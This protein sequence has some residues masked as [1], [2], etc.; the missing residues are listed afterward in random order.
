MGRGRQAAAG[1]G[2]RPGHGGP[3][4]DPARWCRA[5]RCRVRGLGGG[6]RAGR[7]RRAAGGAGPRAPAD[8]ETGIVA[9]QG[10]RSVVAQLITGI[11][12]PTTND[13]ELGK[14][15]H[16]ALLLDGE[17]GAWIGSA[18][19]APSADERVDVEGR[20]VLPGW[21]DSHTHL[22]FAGDRTAEFEA[23]MA[24]KP[25]RAGGIAQTVGATRTASDAELAAN[26]RRHVGE[27]AL[28]G[29][30]CVETKTG[31]GLTVE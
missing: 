24:G 2:R 9:G 10:D 1:R 31:Y 25:Y 26:L 30:T 29:T 5:G 18:A 13:P 6:Y 19:D 8:R 17:R 27:A 22:V 14:L 3:R 7:D 12:E 4:L 20:A 15:H 21:V 28:Q 16:A 11:G 23:R